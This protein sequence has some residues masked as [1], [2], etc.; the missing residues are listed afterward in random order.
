MTLP[1]CW[2]PPDDDADAPPNE[3]RRTFLIGSAVAT[4]A[5]ASSSLST[6]S[7]I[8]ET[9]RGQAVASASHPVSTPINGPDETARG[10]AAASAAS[11]PS[12]VG[13]VDETARGQA[14]ASASR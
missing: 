4:A 14:V 6:G 11:S 2:T 8:N 3:S 1:P 9:A 10:A 13:G 5:G 7:G 12:P